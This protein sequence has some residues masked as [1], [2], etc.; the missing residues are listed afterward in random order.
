MAF[1]DDPAY[2][3][4]VVP[5]ITATYLTDEYPLPPE[6]IWTVM[7]KEYERTSLHPDNLRFE[8]IEPARVKPGQ[9]YEIA[10]DEVIQELRHNL[11]Q[12]A[13]EPAPVYPFGYDWRQPLADIEQQLAAFIDE[14]IE[15]TKL[16]RHYYKAG[17]AD[18]PK[19]NLVGHSMGG[20]I[21]AGLLERSGRQHRIHKVATLATPFQGSLEAVV[22]ATTGNANLG[23][24]E[25]SSREREAARVTPG[26]YHLLPSFA[27][28]LTIPADLPQTLF[29]PDVWQPS[30]VQTIEDYIRLHGVSQADRKVQARNLFTALLQQARAHRQRIDGLKLAAIGMKPADWLCVV[31]VNAKTRVQLSVVKRGK[32]PD[33]EFSRDDIQD[34]WKPDDPAAPAAIRRLTGDNTVP[35][36][37]A[38]PRFLALENLVCV[39][40]GD[41]DF[42]EIKNRALAEAAGF[43]GILPNMDMLHRLIVHHF[44]GR[45]FRP[46]TI[47]GRPAPGIANWQPPI[48]G[49]PARDS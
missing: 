46:D 23:S 26:L 18:D 49:L 8:A 36:E 30:V 34:H 41:F 42:W 11:A 6:Q 35:F 15:R 31:G 13:D 29:D 19:V 40:P 48:P 20:L 45:K 44:T 38:V 17:Y 21:I 27:A 39:T 37:G 7:T 16:L 3:A 10:Y 24:S 14:V 32:A 25:P 28:G 1:P 33:F 4:I 47:W 12:S 2:P 5:G 43:H 9:L 22:K